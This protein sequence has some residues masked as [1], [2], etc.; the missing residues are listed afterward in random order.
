MAVKEPGSD[1]I[2]YNV[3]GDPPF[4]AGAVQDTVA[5][6]TSP[7]ADTFVGASGGAGIV[8]AF[9]EVLVELPFAVVT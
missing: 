2:V 1:V 7:V 9:D 6:P 8:I 4:D 3:M 5:D